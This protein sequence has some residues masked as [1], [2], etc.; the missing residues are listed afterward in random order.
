LKSALKLLVTN[1]L[2]HLKVALPGD[3][4]NENYFEELNILWSGLVVF[5][6]VPK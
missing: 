2:D 3:N 5:K 4:G 1:K 6:S